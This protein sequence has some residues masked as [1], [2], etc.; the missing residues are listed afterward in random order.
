M[1]QLRI[2]WFTVW[3]AG[4]LAKGGFVRS[5]VLLATRT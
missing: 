4:V 2:P 1:S 3:G 5:Y